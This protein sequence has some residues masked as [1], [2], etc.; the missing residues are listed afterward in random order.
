MKTLNLLPEWSVNWVEY[1]D[2]S[3]AQI[4]TNTANLQ[5][6][7]SGNKVLFQV[8]FFKSLV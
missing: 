4:S 6:S 3:Y 7:K 1:N 2:N 5:M 8:T